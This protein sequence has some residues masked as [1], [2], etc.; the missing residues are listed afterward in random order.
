MKDSA[1]GLLLYEVKR[2]LK[3]SH[4]LKIVNFEVS[5]HDNIDDAR[6]CAYFYH[7]LALQELGSNIEHP[8]MF[9]ISN[10]FKFCLFIPHSPRRIYKADKSNSLMKKFVW[11]LYKKA[12]QPE[13]SEDFSL[14]LAEKIPEFILPS[15][16]EIMTQGIIDDTCLMFFDGNIR[17]NSRF[18]KHFATPY[19][20][21]NIEEVSK[22]MPIGYTSSHIKKRIIVRDKIFIRPLQ[23]TP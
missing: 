6:F 10:N 17:T 13:C 21:K 3:A 4:S 16:Y 18:V 8:A 9:E 12:Q 7:G 22:L 14:E 2:P 19:I 11:E 5:I 23:A 1:I 20:G 15:G